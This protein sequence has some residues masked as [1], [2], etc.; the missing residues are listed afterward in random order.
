MRLSR[1]TERRTNAI[2]APSGLT[3]GSLTITM[4]QKFSGVINVIGQ[5]MSPYARQIGP[6]GEHSITVVLLGKGSENNGNSCHIE[7]QP[8]AVSV[9]RSGV[10]MLHYSSS[11]RLQTLMARRR[12]LPRHLAILNTLESH[13]QFDSQGAS[14]LKTDLN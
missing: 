13:T 10:V 2:Q 1:S 12:T 6:D 5:A 3:W 14:D 7:D 9:L 8:S 11:G 4:S